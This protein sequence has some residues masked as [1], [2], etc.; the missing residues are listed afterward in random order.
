MQHVYT[1]LIW[2]DALMGFGLPCQWNVTWVQTW[3]CKKWKKF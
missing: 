2:S 1:D 3:L